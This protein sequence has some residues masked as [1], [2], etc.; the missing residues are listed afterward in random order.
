MTTHRID[1][2]PVGGVVEEPMDARRKGHERS[3]AYV[4]ML[5]ARKLVGT[6]YECFGENG[7]LGTSRAPY[8]PGDVL[9]W[10]GGRATVVSCE[11]VGPPWKW[12]TVVKDGKR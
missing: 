7:F 1:E 11:P 12:K 9:E 6:L 8:S 2:P 4:G 3:G 5:E 10:D